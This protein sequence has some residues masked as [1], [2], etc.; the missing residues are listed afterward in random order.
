MMVTISS[1]EIQ[2]L[3]LPIPRKYVV[4]TTQLVMTHRLF[5]NEQMMSIWLSQCIP[6]VGV[7]P[8]VSNHGA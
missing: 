4:P 6:V 7:V 1:D 5:G 2:R 3:R 8:L